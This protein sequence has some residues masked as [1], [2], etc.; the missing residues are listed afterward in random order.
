MS[1]DPLAFLRGAAL[2][3]TRDLVAAPNSGIVVTSCGDAHV[4]NFGLFTSPERRDVFDATDFDEADQAPFEWDV[5]RLA[6]SLVIAASLEGRKKADQL[7]IATAAAREYRSA[8]RRFAELGRLDVWYSSLDVATLTQ[9]LRGAFGATQRQRL[10]DILR[11]MVVT[12]DKKAAARF[13]SEDSIPQ[14]VV[15]NGHFSSIEGADETGLS[16]ADVEA[17]V[18]DYDASLDSGRQALLGQFSLVDVARHVVGVGSVGTECFAALLCGRDRDDTFF[19]QIKEARPSALSVV[20]NAPALESEAHRIVRAQRILQATPDPF[21]GWTRRDI[22]NQ[23]RSF[24]VRQLY[25]RRG[26]I[27]VHALDAEA[28]LAYGRLCGWTLARAHARAGDSA[29]IAGYLGQG[30]AFDAAIGQFAVA[31]RDRNQVDYDDF[32]RDQKSTD[33]TVQS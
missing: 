7:E 15:T 17:I 32:V 12:S 33:G 9:E 26:S 6:A 5:K 8:M 2:V 19:L 31:Y 16:R 23:V 10:S 28:L 18:R 20:R 1:R 14:I 11:T 4:L 27:D 22:G 3:M 24:Y 30:T 21:L 25:D 29:V 13:T